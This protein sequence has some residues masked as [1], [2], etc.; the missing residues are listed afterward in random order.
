MATSKKAKQ[1]R[2]IAQKSFQKFEQ[3]VK[4]GVGKTIAKGGTRAKVVKGG[5]KGGKKVAKVVGDASTRVVSKT[6][7][8]VGLEEYRLELE[9]ALDEA[10][11]VIAVQEARIARLE[12]QLK[13][14]G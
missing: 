10:V 8:L 7:R 6:T 2:K 14:S 13:K 3:G 11:R 1:T 5:I 12:G 4:S 9:R